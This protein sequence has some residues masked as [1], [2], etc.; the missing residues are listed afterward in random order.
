MPSW[1]VPPCS[2]CFPL[3]SH[4]YLLHS[5]A[6]CGGIQIGGRRGNWRGSDNNNP[7]SDPAL[8]WTL[9]FRGAL[10]LNETPRRFS[11]GNDEPHRA[12]SHLLPNPTQRMSLLVNYL[13]FCHVEAATNTRKKKKDHS[14]LHVLYVSPWSVHQIWKSSTGGT[15]VFLSWLRTPKKVVRSQ[16]RHKT[17][18]NRE[19]CF[20][21]SYSTTGL[22]WHNKENVPSSSHVMLNLLFA[23]LGV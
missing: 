2:D 4:F 20:W 10:K 7:I 16:G 11:C 1:R 21:S 12:A 14:V 18:F 9:A 8:V 13:E 19:T 17:V 15:D 3:K 22:K 23:V 5:L 6:S